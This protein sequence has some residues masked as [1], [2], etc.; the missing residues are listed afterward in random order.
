LSLQI[1]HT[2]KDFS[3][4]NGNRCGNRSGNRKGN[5]SGKKRT[6]DGGR[7]TED[8]IRETVDGIRKTGAG[9]AGNG[10]R[11]PLM[12]GVLVL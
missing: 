9:E 3:L 1:F 2:R 10:E 5:R 4:P 11:R 7:G 6:G 12:T 8:G